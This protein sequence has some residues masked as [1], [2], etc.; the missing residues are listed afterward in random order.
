M[1]KKY[2]MFNTARMH[3]QTQPFARERQSRMEWLYV[4]RQTLQKWPNRSRRRLGGG[5][6]CVS[7]RNHV[8]DRVEIGT[9]WQIYVLICVAAVMWAVATITVA[10]YYHSG[11]QLLW[12][13]TLL[14][15]LL[16]DS[17]VSISLAYMVSD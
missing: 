14:L 6:T 12:P 11:R 5:K 2:D 17:Q 10:T 15:T 16:S 13:K 1:N 4:S 7:P 9:T 8:L 3:R